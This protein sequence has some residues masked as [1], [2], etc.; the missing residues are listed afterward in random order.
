M[1]FDC[2][3]YR[4]KQVRGLGNDA[5]VA[6]KL[7]L[8]ISCPFFLIYVLKYH[9]LNSINKYWIFSYIFNNVEQ[10]LVDQLLLLILTIIAVIKFK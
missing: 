10:I 8:P 4:F 3:S 1:H 7:S 5:S 2:P 9:F 6:T